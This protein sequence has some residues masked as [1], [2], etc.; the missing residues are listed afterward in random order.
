M[1]SNYAVSSCRCTLDDVRGICLPTADPPYSQCSFSPA[2]TSGEPGVSDH[3][4]PIGDRCR[5][6]FTIHPGQ[7]A[8]EQK[9]NQFT[10]WTNQRSVLPF[11]G[12]LS[13]I[14]FSI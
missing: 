14:C 7:V 1:V 8:Y 12:W 11:P 6:W 2:D 10:K 9:R 13:T 4:Q 3:S 5:S